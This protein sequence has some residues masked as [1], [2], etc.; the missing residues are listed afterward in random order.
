MAI[1][2]AEQLS[3]NAPM[4]FI[5]ILHITWLRRLVWGIAACL[6]LAL[7]AWQTLPSLI[8]SQAE[9]RGSEALGRKLTLGAVDFKPWTLELSVSDIHV[10]SADGKSTQLSIARLHADAALQSLWRMAPVLDALSIEQPQL[11]L[12]HLG[13]GHYDIDDVLARL[14]PAPDAPATAP[15]RYALYNLNVKDAAVDF[16]DHIG[17]GERHH[18]LRKLQASLP[19]LSSFDSQRDVTVQPH[20]AFELNGSAFDSA[21]QI[22]P[23]AQS[24]KGEVLLQVTHLDLAPY[25]PYLPAGLPLRLK[26][27]VLDS[28]LKLSFEQ[29]QTSKL[30]ISGAAKLSDIRLDDPSGA[31]FLSVASVQA[32]LK[33][34]RPLEHSVALESL[35]L[36]NPRLWVGRNRAGQWLPGLTDAQPVAPVARAAAAQASQPVA[37]PAKAPSANTGW[38]VAVDRIK[39]QGGQVRLADDSVAPAV[40][41]ALAN[42]QLQLRD[43][44]WP[45]AKPA[46]F[47]ATAQL[48][49]QDA[50]GGKPVGIALQ[51]EATD[52]AGAVTAKVTDLGLSLAA[53]Y[54]AQT[55]VPQVSGVLEGELSASWKEGGALQIQAKRLALHDF[56]LTPP[57][58]K[59]DIAAKDLPAFKLLEV[60]DVSVDVP[61]HVASVGKLALQSPRVRVSRADD[62]QWMFARWLRSGPASA[63]APASASASAQAQAQAQAQ[64]AKAVPPA[65]VAKTSTAAWSLALAELAVDEGTLSWVDRV[66]AKTVFLELS[67]LQARSK[68]LSLDGK[69]PVPLSLSA[70]VRSARTDPGSLRF[71]GTLAWDPL[72]AQGA[73]EA[74]QFPAQAV[75]PYGLGHLPLEVLRADTSFKGQLRYASLPAGPAVQLRGDGAIEELQV[76]SLMAAARAPAVK[77]ADAS[78][79]R[80]EAASMAPTA[81]A[82]ASEELL[83]WKA[84]SLPGIELTLTP[85]TPLQLKVREVSLSDFFA[86]LI[87][88]AQG[89]LVLQDLVNPEDD[90]TEAA[91]APL[92]GASAPAAPVAAA[93][94]NDP[95][96]DIGTIR[97]VNGRVAFSDRF[98]KPNYSA[99]LTELAGSLSHFRS[100]NPQGGVQMAD[101]ELRGRAEGTASLEITGKLNPLAKPLALD[102]H[103][104]VRDLELSPLSSYAIKYAGYGIER[105][106]LSVDLNYSVSPD[107]MLQ[108]SNQIILNQLVFGDAVEGASSPLPVKLAV[109]LLADSN[110]V[111]D[112]NVPLS[113]SLNDPQFRVW[114]LVWKVLGNIVAKAL[115]SPFSLISGLLGGDSAADELSNVAF[116][117]GTA[118]ISA[119]GPPG[120]DTIAQALR[121][122]P[123]LRLTVVGTASLEREAD[124]IKRERLQGLLL[125]EKRR[126]AATAGKDVTAVAA[127][128][129]EETPALLKEVYRRSGIKKPRN[130]V[131]LTKDLPAADMEALLL[132]SLVVDEDTVRELALGRAIAVREYLTARQLPS[133]RLFL[134][135]VDTAA[136]AAD[137]QPRAELSIEH[138]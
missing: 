95:V 77:A 65:G 132:A 115:T 76:N 110:G 29:A 116:D 40:R 18:S 15:L 138:H 38:Q 48:Q 122:K 7:L 44:H 90:E 117:I 106:K 86:R 102:I 87:V 103:A 35:D 16:V 105:G 30:L 57:A 24:R 19:F 136:T 107:G 50:K 130:L 21:A 82:A 39:L 99:N 131:G 129:P 42:T 49:A 94:A 20:L 68:N 111:I 53:P 108:A 112:L 22:T 113:G 72:V 33:E 124:A 67:A 137:W 100:Q 54:L 63:Q 13:D 93:T 25:L 80:T 9:W 127:V 12:T 123:G 109:A 34:L 126:V 71:E 51:G 134:G 37:S 66:P 52:L 114:P 64:V 59:S 119:A 3:N 91:A 89:R 79:S 6:G 104:K 41:L 83:N 98:I 81:G 46:H 88:N 28:S 17:G 118:H 62:G 78:V 36:N 45:F 32:V 135:Q 47:E 4:K 14:Q 121:D 120:L 23:F 11:A 8:K 73:L 70:K 55:L 128:T 58:G 56:A 5:R 97:L 43:L 101:L 1:L 26:S 84:L 60:S 133:E 75:A 2:G 27:A 31:P 61:Q 10:A 85:G 96:I 74:R 69:K 92:A 125:A